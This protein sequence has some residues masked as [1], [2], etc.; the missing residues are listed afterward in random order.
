[1]QSKAKTVNEYVKELPPDR[2]REIE[3]VRKVI[4][5]NLPTGYKEMMQWGMISYAVPLSLYP[6]GYGGKSDVPLPYMGLA[7]QKNYMALYL[8]CV[9]GNKKVEGWFRKEYKKSGKKLDMGKGC[10]RFKTLN[11][12]PLELIGKTV[13][14]TPVKKFIEIYEK[15]RKR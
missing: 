14:I 15:A 8:M 1:M 5:K 11:D 4:K 12:L 13:A 6:K 3:I 7:S 9:Y 10:V 2:R